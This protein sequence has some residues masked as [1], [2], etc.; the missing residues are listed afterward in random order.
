MKV[1]NVLTAFQQISAFHRR[2][3]PRLTVAGITG[4][5]G[6][7]STKEMI[8]AI[9]NRY[10]GDPDAVLY[11]IGNTNNHIGVPQNLLR[12]F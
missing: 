1:D 10:A 6:K 7:T 9:F 12:E 11:T 2:R 5:V 3:F 4:S 8:R